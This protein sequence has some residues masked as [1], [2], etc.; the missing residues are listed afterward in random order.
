MREEFK[1]FIH[2]RDTE[3]T[4]MHGE[5]GCLCEISV[6]SVCLHG[7]KGMLPLAGRCLNRSYT[8]GED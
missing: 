1:H 4:K 8:L 3:Y 5:P 6:P 7:E 2:H